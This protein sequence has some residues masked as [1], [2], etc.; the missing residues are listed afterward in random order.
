MVSAPAASARSTAA[1]TSSGSAAG[2]D[3]PVL[4]GPLGDAV[5]P[6][7]RSEGR[8]TAREE[9]VG[10]RHLEARDLEDVLEAAGREEG[11]RRPPALDHRV[12]P[13][14]GPVR[15]VADRV[16]RPPI[17]ARERRDAGHHLGAGGLGGREGLVGAQRSRRLVED[18]EVGERPADV[19]ADAKPGSR[20][21]PIHSAPPSSPSRPVG[22]LA[23]KPAGRI[24][25]A[26]RP[27]SA[28]PPL[29]GSSYRVPGR[30]AR[31]DPQIDP[32]ERSNAR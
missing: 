8:R 21:V 22:W 9:V 2:L 19:D 1:A 10:V 18:A 28:R 14:G 16:R 26:A 25:S 3:A 32:T 23:G 29:G 27:C 24:P 17:P 6:L 15:E 20:L 13:H 5:D 11:E 12:H 7:A 31:I 30:Y 4:Q